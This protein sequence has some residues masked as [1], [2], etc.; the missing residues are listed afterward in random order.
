MLK[1]K[2]K[3][4]SPALNHTSVQLCACANQVLLHNSFSLSPLLIQPQSVT[5]CPQLWADVGFSSWS[6]SLQAAA[7]CFIS[8]TKPNPTTSDLKVAGQNCGFQREQGIKRMKNTSYEKTSLLYD[9]PLNYETDRQAAIH[10]YLKIEKWQ[11]R[12][13][14]LKLQEHWTQ[15]LEV[16]LQ[17]EDYST[18]Q[19]MGKKGFLT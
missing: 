5:H 14:L 9:F 19:I 15:C 2:T 17:K 13:Q 8:R 18:S 16:Y 1:N 11:A 7:W 10:K 12:I 6:G 4:L 3:Q